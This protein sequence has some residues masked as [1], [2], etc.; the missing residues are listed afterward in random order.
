MQATC[1]LWHKKKILEHMERTETQRLHQANNFDA[2][3]LTA[4]LAVLYSHQYPVT[5]TVPPSWMNVAMIGGIAVM[6]FFVI[7]GYLVT[8]SWFSQPRLWAFCAKR[9]LRI[10]PALATVV[11]LAML[12]LGPSVT[13]LPLRDYFSH[14][15]TWDYLHNILLQIRFSLPGV[16]ADNTFPNAVNGSLWTIPIEVSCY[17]VLAAAGVLGLMRWRWVWACIC[18]AYLLWFLTHMTM[19]LRG[20]MT[21]WWEFPAYFAFGSLIATFNQQ[22]L[23]RRALFAVIACA[24][25]LVAYALGFS[26]SALLLFLPAVLLAVGTVSWPVLSQAGRFGDV[27]Y[28]VYLY[29]FPIQQSVR[30]LAPD[31]GFSSSLAIVAVLTLL[32]GW[33]SWRLVEQPALRLKVYL[34]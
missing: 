15:L 26:Y 1:R 12:V 2:L 21:H 20:T 24:C 29:A 8:I 18:V 33:L 10:W 28:G 3:R 9:A 32:A 16:F 27:S 19:D 13:T 22:F 17:A 31:L 30:F 25:A 4:A 34:R 23:Q 5:G 7:S 11:L 14:S 6:A